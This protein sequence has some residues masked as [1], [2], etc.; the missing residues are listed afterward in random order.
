MTEMILT[1]IK[2]NDIISS[3][4]YL[5]NKRGQVLNKLYLQYIYTSAGNCCQSSNIAQTKLKIVQSK[6]YLQLLFKIIGQSE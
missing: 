2:D 3:S 1:A 5:W 6:N 4:I